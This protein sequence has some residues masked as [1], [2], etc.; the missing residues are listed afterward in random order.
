MRA[1][2]A[3]P[4]STP[5]TGRRSATGPCRGGRRLYEA[6]VDLAGPLAD[7][8]AHLS[9]VRDKAIPLPEPMAALLAEAAEQLNATAAD[10]PL[11]ALRAAGVLE[12]I[13]DRVSR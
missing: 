12:R 8:T 4:P 11:A 3:A 6:D 2:G 1:D 13:A 9:V 7:W 5:W 10:A